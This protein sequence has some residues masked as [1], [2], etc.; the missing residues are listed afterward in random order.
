MSVRNNPDWNGASTVPNARSRLAPAL[1]SRAL[2]RR[3]MVSVWVYYTC[4]CFPSRFHRHARRPRQNHEPAEYEGFPPELW[5]HVFPFLT[6]LKMASKS[7][8]ALAQPLLF[9]RIVI[10]P[11]C[12]QNPTSGHLMC[13][14]DCLEWFTERMQFGTQERIAREVITIE[15]SPCETG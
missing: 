4:H 1:F 12:G 8:A 15:L 10:R 11:P 2:T 3:P 5:L 14:R 6:N 13:R 7:F 9:R